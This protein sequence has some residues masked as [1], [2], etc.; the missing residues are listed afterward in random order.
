MGT[1]PKEA[2]I[3]VFFSTAEASAAVLTAV[4]PVLRE[5]VQV[6]GPAEKLLA[7]EMAG[8]VE[9]DDDER[10]VAVQGAVRSFRAA[11]S[12]DGWAACPLPATHYCLPCLAAHTEVVRSSR[13]PPQR[14]SMAQPKVHPINAYAKNGAHGLNMPERLFMQIFVWRAD[15]SHEKGWDTG[16]RSEPIYM[17][18]NLHATREPPQLE[19]P[20]R[21]VVWQH[22]AKRPLN[23]RGLLVALEEEDVEKVRPVASD[24]DALLLGSR[25]VTFEPLPPDQVQL[26]RWLIGCVDGVLAEPGAEPWMT[27]WLQVLQREG[28]K[29]LHPE[30][31]PFGFGD[32]TSYAIFK[33]IVRQVRRSGAV[34]HGAECFNFYF[35]Q[36][37]CRL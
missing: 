28:A 2:R 26:M 32:P 9:I 5:M 21:A 10:E 7:D 4:Q 13:A 15:I 24:F 33:S 30:I 34:R 3:R 6:S 8:R 16:R 18:L 12:C 31:P 35:P 22:D 17:D 1:S 36:V 29:G 11:R 37:S 14:W 20:P 27:R 23:P 19:G 25:G